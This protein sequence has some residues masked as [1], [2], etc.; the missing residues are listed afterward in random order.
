MAG[1]TTSDKDIFGLAGGLRSLV[2][3]Y[4]KLVTDVET[5]RAALDA[6]CDLLDADSG[7]NGTTY[8]ATAAVTTAAALT[9]A[10]VGNDQGTALTA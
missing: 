1:T 10:K 3:N 6:V 5:L 9:A 4:N 2:V 7:V 8:A